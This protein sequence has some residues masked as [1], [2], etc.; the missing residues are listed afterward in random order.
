MLRSSLQI[1]DLLSF[2]IISFIKI[3]FADEKAGPET[4]PEAGK[5]ARASYDNGRCSNGG[6]KLWME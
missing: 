5:N 6:V 1:F 4:I 3:D 2:A